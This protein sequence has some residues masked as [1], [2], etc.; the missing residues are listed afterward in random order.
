[1]K[2]LPNLQIMLK[3]AWKNYLSRFDVILWVHVLVA[4]PV[5]LVVDASIPRTLLSE[6]TYDLVDLPLLLLEPAYQF[7]VVV[8]LAANLVLIYVLVVIVLALKYSYR[9]QPVSFKQLLTSGFHWFP[10][11]IITALVIGFL[12]MLGLVFLIIPGVILSIILTI[13]IPA[14]IWYDLSP[15][16]AV[17]KTWK[18]VRPNFWMALAYIMIAQIIV[19]GAAMLIILVIPD[20]FGFYGIGLTISAIFQSYL[21]VFATVLMTSLEEI[22]KQSDN[23]QK[24]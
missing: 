15:V 23:K 16:Q 24:Q 12:Q 7:N 4:F 6:T 13:T 14:L 5:Y 20:A 11:A 2:P 10:K 9:Q 17:R 21:F 3:L 8:T 18:L 1:M 19:S 22:Q